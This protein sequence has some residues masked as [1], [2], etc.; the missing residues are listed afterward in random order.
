MSGTTGLSLAVTA[1][2]SIHTFQYGKVGFVTKPYSGA[3][4]P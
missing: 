2:Y 4:S 3:E 1:V